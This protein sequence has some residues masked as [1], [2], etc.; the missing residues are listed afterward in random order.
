MQRVRDRVA[1]RHAGIEREQDPRGAGAV[2]AACGARRRGTTAARAANEIR[3]ST[4][5]T[6]FVL[7]ETE[8]S[9]TE[10]VSSATEMP[11]ER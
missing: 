7:L 2:E 4:Q 8:S 9:A 11:Q 3:K 6:E 5:T 1:E 10:T